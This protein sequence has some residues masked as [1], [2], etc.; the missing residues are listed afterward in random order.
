M[1]Y[2]ERKENCKLTNQTPDMSGFKVFKV[3]LLV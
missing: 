2:K 1:I 3:Q